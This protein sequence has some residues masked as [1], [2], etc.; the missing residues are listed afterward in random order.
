VL[1]EM[2]GYQFSAAAGDVIRIQMSDGNSSTGTITN[3]VLLYDPEGTLIGNVS[4]EGMAIVQLT[5]PVAGEYL[6]I[7]R[8]ASGNRT[9]NYALNIQSLNNPVGTVPISYGETLTGTISRLGEMDVYAFDGMADDIV[10]LQM[11]DGNSS[12]GTLT[13]WVGVYDTTGTLIKSAVGEG[14]AAM[15]VTLPE[16]GRYL[17]V[18]QD[19]SGN[20]TGYGLS[21]QSL[22]T[23][24]NTTALVYGEGRNKSL[25]VLGEMDGYQFSA[26]AGDVIRIQMSDGNSSIGTI[27]NSV[28]LYDSAGTIIGNVSGESTA[29][30]N[31]TLNVTG[32]YLIIARDASGDRA[33]GYSLNLQLQ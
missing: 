1:G 3:S 28:L 9:G 4:R 18:A 22:N 10:R 33:G 20:R 16:T 13:N 12:T 15:N 30:L 6:I 29:T 8:D 27:T 11:S 5:L 7:A 32:S 14:M 21:L 23:P 26:A 2:D 17:I 31:V 25:T 24:Q 19:A